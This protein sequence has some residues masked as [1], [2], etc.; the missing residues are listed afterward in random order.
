VGSP[1][2]ALSILKAYLAKHGHTVRVVY[3]NI[4]LYEL[5]NEFT[6]NKCHNVQGASTLIYAA[7]LAVKTQNKSLFNE[8]KAALQTILPVMLNEKDFFEEHIEQYT[9]KLEQFI[10]NYLD[11]FDNKNI[12]YFGF[13]VNMNQW[14]LASVVAEKIKKRTPNIPIVIEEIPTDEI[15]KA[16]LENFNQFDIAIRGEWEEPMLEF[17][18]FLVN[19]SDFSNFNIERTFYR[20][21]EIVRESATKKRHYLDL[22]ENE[23]YPDFS[24]YFNNR[25]QTK[26]AAPIIYLVIEGSRGC[27]WNRCRFCFLN[28]GYRYRQKSIEKIADEIKY[29]I[30][31]YKIYSFKFVENDLI[32]KDISRFHSL[33]D[34]LVIIKK[35]YPNFTI[36][37]EVVTNN[38][39]QYTIKKMRDAGIVSI[40]IGFESAS[41][42]LLKKIDKENTYATNL[43]T[44]KHCYEV[45]IFVGGA[46]ILFSLPEE[47]EEDIYEAIENFRFFRFIMN[48]ETVF[49]FRPII[50]KINSS[51]RY[52][53]VIY[54][55]KHK[56][57]PKINLYHKA[58]LNL[59]DE[60]TKWHLFEYSLNHQDA[61]WDYFTDLQYHYTNNHYEYKFNHEKDK[62]IYQEFLNKELSEHIE[63]EKNELYIPILDYCYDKPVSINELQNMLFQKDRN[64]P[65]I[66]TLVEKIDTLFNQGL[67][68]RTTDYTEITSIVNIKKQ[69]L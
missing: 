6:W 15:A 9:E 8:V 66:E 60:E 20:E 1:S 18:H 51:S 25:K 22:S 43:N 47:T 12:L 4:L 42:C 63:F 37:G 35:Q 33:L 14:V 2:A 41:N 34:E 17:T 45:G 57:I 44:I 26:I 61:K 29:L 27:H 7:Y 52:Y 49:T 59:F 68:Y 64:F 30:S 67:L 11:S 62:I 16:F 65:D 32:G 24:D 50:L 13:S 21:N 58:F 23:L 31:I 10:D 3:W 53:K 38:L 5:E 46:N 39:S 40:Q 36:V 48:K 69:E 54:D 19:G 55:C 28:R 56:Y